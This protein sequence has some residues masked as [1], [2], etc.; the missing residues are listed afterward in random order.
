MIHVNEFVE[1][2]LNDLAMNGTTLHELELKDIRGTKCRFVWVCLWLIQ[3]LSCTHTEPKNELFQD[4]YKLYYIQVSRGFSNSLHFSSFLFFFLSFFSFSISCSKEALVP[5]GSR[6][7]PS[8][9]LVHLLHHVFSFSSISCTGYY[10]PISSYSLLIFS[11]NWMPNYI[12][13]VY[14]AEVVKARFLSNW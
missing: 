6:L 4:L 8:L 2:H 10:P 7:S 12:S 14:L 1:G 3:T 9:P 5:C 13:I 11:I